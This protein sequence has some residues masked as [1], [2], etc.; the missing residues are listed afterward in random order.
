[1][2]FAIF[3]EIAIGGIRLATEAIPLIRAF[4]ERKKD[5]TEKEWRKYSDK[6]RSYI[7]DH[8]EEGIITIDPIK[9]GQATKYTVTENKK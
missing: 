5:F 2:N 4:A 1:M 9:R 6:F 7:K 3:I 8:P